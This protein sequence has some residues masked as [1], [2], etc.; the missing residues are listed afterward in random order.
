MTIRTLVKKR[1]EIL[2]QN[3]DSFGERLKESIYGVLYVLLK[4]DHTPV[5]LHAIL[6]AIEILEFMIFPFS[7]AV[8][9]PWANASLVKLFHN[10]FSK[11]NIV[12]YLHGGSQIVFLITFYVNV[13][14]VS[15]II[16]NIAYVSYSFS[17]KYFTVTWPLYVLRT[18]AKIY[19]TILLSPVFELFLSIFSCYPQGAASAHRL[20][21]SVDTSTTTTSTSHSTTTTHATEVYVLGISPEYECYAWSHYLHMMISFIVT[22]T[23]IIIGLIVGMAFFENSEVAEDHGAK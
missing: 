23:F 21:S 20:L 16:I 8:A 22:V 7:D 3:K 18:M 5:F 17:R 14:A 13:A 2:S 19:I 6:L 10:L 11:A 4:D 9:S 1:S 15:L 12:S